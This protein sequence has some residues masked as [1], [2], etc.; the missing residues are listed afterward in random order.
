VPRGCSAQ[1][2]P[3]SV[4][5]KRYGADDPDVGPPLVQQTAAD[6]QDTER[7]GKA[8]VGVDCLV[9][10]VPPLVVAMTVAEFVESG[11]TA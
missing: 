4:V 7:S 9:Q 11:P 8:C 10:V 2:A 5:A 3:P 6:A 1:W